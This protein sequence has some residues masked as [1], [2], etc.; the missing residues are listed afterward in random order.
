MTTLRSLWRRLDPR[1]RLAARL[2]VALFLTFALPGAILVFLLERRLSAIEESTESRVAAARL[3]EET[4]RLHQDAE[5]RAQSMDRGA[6]V[7]EEA[8]W[9]LADAARVLLS[10]A[11]AG[12]GRG[13]AGRRA[14]PR[15][16]RRSECPL[17]RVHLARPLGRRRGAARP[18]RNP[19][20][21]SAPGGRAPPAAGRPHGLALD[22]FG[23]RARLSLG[24]PA[25]GDPQLGRRAGAVPV[26]PAGAV[27]NDAV[28]A[29]GIAPSGRPPSSAR[30]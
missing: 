23:R 30:R 4:M 14:R 26:Q 2:L 1:R 9:S 29:R 24:G 6:R 21:R 27:S 12:G 5:M 11:R 25:R 7:A 17:A 28:S 3:G 19:G 20:A 8:A 15:L 18:R 13:P 16:E 10:G 22:G